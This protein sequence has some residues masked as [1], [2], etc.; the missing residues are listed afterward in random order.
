MGVLSFSLN[1]VTG[2]SAAW[3]FFQCVESVSA[4]WFLMIFF[5]WPLVMSVVHRHMSNHVIFCM[6]SAFWM[7]AV[8]TGGKSKWG[9]DLFIGYL[10]QLRET[11]NQRKILCD[12]FTLLLLKEKLERGGRGEPRRTQR[13]NEGE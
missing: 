13:K 6:M 2:R 7:R 1:P 10:T 11:P 12:S 8:T 9:V 3:S 5:D 4:N